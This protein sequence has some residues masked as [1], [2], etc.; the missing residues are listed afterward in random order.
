MR[1]DALNLCICLDRKLSEG[2]YP[3]SPMFNVFELDKPFKVSGN[4]KIPKPVIASTSAWLLE[5]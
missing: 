2:W 4:V 5:E 1:L 3:L